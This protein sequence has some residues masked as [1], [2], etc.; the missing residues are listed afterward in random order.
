MIEAAQ[1]DGAGPVR[2]FFYVGAPMGVP[3]LL[4]AFVLGFFECWS[5]I[6]QPMTLLRNPALWPLSLYLPQI[7][8]SSLGK[9]LAAS[10]IVLA[11]ALLLF[12]YGQQYLEQGISAMGIKE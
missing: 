8:A 7:H 10:V 3:G 5:M 6:E 12:L 11:P 1:L 9:S 2:V 4:S